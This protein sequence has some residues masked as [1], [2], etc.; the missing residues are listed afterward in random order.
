MFAEQQI[1]QLSADN[2]L[3]NEKNSSLR[4]ELANLEQMFTNNSIEL[5]NYSQ[6]LAHSETELINRMN[7]VTSLKQTLAEAE[8]ERTR[9]LA[10]LDEISTTSASEKRTYEGRVEALI[11]RNEMLEKLLADARNEVNARSEAFRAAERGQVEL[12]GTIRRLEKTTEKMT[13]D[14]ENLQNEIRNL[15]QA[16]AAL[17]DR[18]NMREKAHKAKDTV[19]SQ[20]EDKMAQL[21]EQLS[22]SEH[23]NRLSM[24]AQSKRIAELI[25]ELEREKSERGLAEGRLE[26]VRKERTRLQLEL[27]TL[28]AR[29]MDDGN[30]NSS[31]EDDGDGLPRNSGNIKSFRPDPV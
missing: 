28:R 11:K 13:L 5:N 8:N 25:T 2:R 30:F 7:Q 9:L 31:D 3:L 17:K 24:E 6:R 29:Y 26:S 23:K 12:K 21:S 14:Q 19:I 27:S 18:T 1:N 15:E 22:R 10:Q 16:R 20:S 4:E